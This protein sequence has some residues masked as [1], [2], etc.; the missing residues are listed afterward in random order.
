[1]CRGQYHAP[2]LLHHCPSLDLSHL[3]SGSSITPG[4]CIMCGAAFGG[5]S[6]ICRHWPCGQSRP[7]LEGGTWPFSGQQ[8]KWSALLRS[9]P[10]S[11]GTWTLLPLRPR[12][13][14]SSAPGE[15]WRAGAESECCHV[16]SLL[17]AVRASEGQETLPGVPGA[18]QGGDMFGCAV[19]AAGVALSRE[20]EQLGHAPALGP[21]ASLPS[22]LRAAA[23]GVLEAAAQDSSRRRA[24]SSPSLQ[25]CPGILPLG[26]LELWPVL[27]YSAASSLCHRHDLGPWLQLL[28]APQQEQPC[29]RPPPP[30]AP[31]HA[32]SR[33]LRAKGGP[34]QGCP[35]LARRLPLALPRAPGLSAQAP[36]SGTP[37]R[38]PGWS[39]RPGAGLHSLVPRGPPGGSQS[40]HRGS[41]SLRG[42]PLAITQAATGIRTGPC[43]IARVASAGGGLDWRL[44]LWCA[45]G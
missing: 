1:L 6:E 37:D 14:G 44:H 39:V 20:L 40:G 34:E 11:A 35:V 9:L 27:A 32:A 15:G 18:F 3:L 23:Q 30:R 41:L 28:C 5:S 10:S 43:Q 17:A 21:R 4:C 42:P 24:C 25:A 33:H 16:E 45:P 29:R 31:L 2:C 19:A 22:S 8:E 12:A 36:R 38:A 7:A 13:Q 26:A